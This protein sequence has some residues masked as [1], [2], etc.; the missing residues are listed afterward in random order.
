MSPEGSTDKTAQ[1]R[2]FFEGRSDVRLAYLFGSRAEGTAREDSDYDVGVLPAED[3]DPGLRFELIQELGELLGTEQVD[4]VMLDRAPHELAF[5]VI[6]RGEP[7]YAPDEELRV[8][9]EARVMSR[10]FD[11]LP[12]LRRQRRDIIEE[13]IS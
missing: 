12:V 5:C 11:Y 10:Y 13:A 9:F 3:A 2:S 4:V 8:D 1:L 6:D 7:V